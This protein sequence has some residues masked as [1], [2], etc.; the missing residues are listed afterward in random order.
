MTY[1][2]LSDEHLAAV[3]RQTMKYAMLWQNIGA[4]EAFRRAAVIEQDD[5]GRWKLHCRGVGD[6]IA[7]LQHEGYT[8]HAPKVQT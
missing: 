3:T 8:I 6:T 5:P 2:E 4:D 1:Y 7:A